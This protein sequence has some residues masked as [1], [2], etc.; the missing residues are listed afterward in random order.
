MYYQQRWNFGPL[1]NELGKKRNLCL[2]GRY[3]HCSRPSSSWDC[4]F[5]NV[6]SK[7]IIVVQSVQQLHIQVHMNSV[8]DIHP[9]HRPKDWIVFQPTR[10]RISDGQ[11]TSPFVRHTSGFNPFRQSLHVKEKVVCKQ[12]VMCQHGT[13]LY[14]YIQ[15]WRCSR[16]GKPH[17]VTSTPKQKLII[18]YNDE[19][20]VQFTLPTSVVVRP[21]GPSRRR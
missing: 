18:T 20:L 16:C 1:Q 9:L 10:L 13:I 6:R 15:P 19:K 5:H 17:V 3:K 14:Q 7:M 21:P 11:D 2:W 12:A 8:D 4:G